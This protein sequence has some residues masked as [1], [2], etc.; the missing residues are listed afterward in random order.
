MDHFHFQNGRAHAEEVDLTTLTTRFNS[1]FYV[2]S[3]ATLTHHTKVFQAAFADK[4][5]KICYAVKANGNLAVLDVLARAGCGFDIV[6]GG[7]LQRVLAAGGK[8]EDVVFSGIGKTIDEIDRALVTGIACFNVE[9]ESELKR[10]AN[11]AKHLGMI[12]PIS[13]RINPDVDPKT[14]P[15]IST[16]MRENKFG[17]EPE[18][19][20]GLYQWANEQP[21]LN[22]QGVDCHIGSQITTLDPFLDALDAIVAFA[23]RLRSTGICIN[24]LDIGGGLGV[25]YHNESPPSPADY[26]SAIRKRYSHCPYTLILEPGR[27]IAANAGVL[28]TKVEFIKSTPNKRFAI[29][30]AGMND[31]LRPALYQAWHDILPV[32]EAPNLPTQTYDVVGP[33]CE[34]ADC[35]GQDRQ[36]AIDEGSHLM[37]R[38]CGAYGFVMS[39]QYNARPRLAE[40]MVAGDQWQIVRPA[41]TLEDLYAGEQT[42]NIHSLTSKSS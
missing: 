27:A 17:I 32:L 26:A 18:T 19:A 37:I 12:A 31:L 9:S 38:G 41:E 29:I 10:I 36:L 3:S 28:I 25:P 4:P 14:H 20:F 42:L 13:L 30:D 34:T 7:E 11:R 2:Y 39:S 35:F 16:G 1:P 15:Y 6:S 40:I 5:H 21:Q 33:V 24:H 23:D 8:A 22:I